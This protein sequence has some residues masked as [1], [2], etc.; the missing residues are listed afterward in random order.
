MSKLEKI[1]RINFFVFLGWIIIFLLGA[2]FPP[3]IGFIWMVL[4][5]FILD[6]VQS[7]Y[8]KK[9]FL[10]RIK[11]RKNIKLFFM[12]ALFYLAGSLIVAGSIAIVNFQKMGLM[13][14]LIWT[15]VVTLVGVLY[16]SIFCVFNI[17]LFRTIK[18]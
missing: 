14:A 17:I 12:N 9:Y 7:Y 10:V 8:L 3:P 16:G 4:L 11:N 6:I 15:A 18:E 5:V 1:I 13:N 2:D